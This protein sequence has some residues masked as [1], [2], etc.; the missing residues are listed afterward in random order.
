MKWDRNIMV[1][2]AHACFTKRPRFSSS[3]LPAVLVVFACGGYGSSVPVP[4]AV[5]GG[6]SGGEGTSVGSAGHNDAPCYDY[7]N[8]DSGEPVPFRLEVLPLLQRSCATGLACHA[9]IKGGPLQPYL[10][11][12]SATPS[13]QVSDVQLAAIRDQNVNVDSGGAPGMKRAAPGDPEHSFL[14]HKI[15]G[16]LK[17]DIVSCADTC[18]LAMPPTTKP[19]SPVEKDTIRRWI[20]HGAVIE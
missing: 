9:S 12:T 19:L 3:L 20:A 2:S 13:E 1:Y 14:M 17:C 10:G 15:D 8:F 18:G 11:P 5:G 16:T 7:T 4:T 6:G